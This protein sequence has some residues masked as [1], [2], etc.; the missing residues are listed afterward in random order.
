MWECFGGLFVFFKR[1]GSTF[2][3][4]HTRSTNFHHMLKHSTTI[5]HIPIHSTNNC[6]IP[7][8][9][10]TFYH[11]RIFYLAKEPLNISIY[12]QDHLRLLLVWQLV[13]CYFVFVPK[14]KV[15]IF[16]FYRISSLF[17]CLRLGKY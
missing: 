9:S 10:H 1:K 17:C 3:S 12:T 2:Q 8:H 4:S 5:G 7:K 15:H 11:T 14:Q 16:L 6:H 13:N